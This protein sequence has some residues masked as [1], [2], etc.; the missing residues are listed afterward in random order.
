MNQA[1]LIVKQL[2]K[3]YSSIKTVC[4]EYETKAAPLNTIGLVLDKN[5]IKVPKESTKNETV[6]F[7]QYNSLL[8]SILSTCKDQANKMGTTKIPLSTLEMFF[9]V[10]KKGIIEGSKQIRL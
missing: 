4:K 9:D 6:F 2:D 10:T 5:K 7:K 8:D 3:I 1:E